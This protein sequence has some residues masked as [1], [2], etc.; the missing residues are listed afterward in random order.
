MQ[1][2]RNP[3]AL[4]AKASP[5]GAFLLMALVPVL[6]LPSALAQTNS[7]SPI[8]FVVKEGKL[9]SGPK[10]TQLKQDDSVTLTIVS[11]RADELHLHVFNLKW[12]L[13]LSQ[14]GSLSFIANH[15]GRF[16]LE[17]HKSGLELGALEVYPK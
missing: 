1:S 14:P 9:V 8:S 7:D 17:L 15:T 13:E 16:Q 6:S 5:T 3:L 4:L 12:K 11:D 2:S 10:V